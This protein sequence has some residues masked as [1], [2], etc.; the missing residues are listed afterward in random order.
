MSFNNVINKLSAILREKVFSKIVPD[1]DKEWKIV[2]ANARARAHY[3]ARSLR[4]ICK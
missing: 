3:S 2:Q 1:A 4:V